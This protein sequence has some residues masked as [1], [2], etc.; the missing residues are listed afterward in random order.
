MFDKKWYVEHGVKEHILDSL[1]L[2]AKQAVPTG[3]FL[4]SVLENDLFGAMGKADL[5]N[6]KTLFE[7][8]RYIHNELPSSCFGSKEIVENWEGIEGDKNGSKS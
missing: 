2:W 5:H 8:C 6:R 7:I 4:K 1:N 3:G